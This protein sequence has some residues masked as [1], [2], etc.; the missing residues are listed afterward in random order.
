[1]QKDNPNPIQI[2]LD[3]DCRTATLIH[4]V[5]FEEAVGIIGVVFGGVSAV[6]HKYQ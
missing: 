2:H 1:M 3:S 4:T 6:I 5:L